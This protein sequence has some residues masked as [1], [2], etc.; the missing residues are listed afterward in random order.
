M[1]GRKEKKGRLERR[2]RRGQWDRPAKRETLGHRVSG[3][4]REQT[5][6]AGRRAFK[7]SK[8]SPARQVKQGCV[9]SV[10][11][12]GR[13]A[14]RVNAARKEQWVLRVRRARD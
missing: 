10:E 9:V 5:G 8:E 6:S 2:G 12:V 1:K 7:G 4:F 13:Q 3:A 11:S 14:P